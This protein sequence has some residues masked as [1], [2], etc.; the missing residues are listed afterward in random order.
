M[1]F[2]G[3]SPGAD[4]VTA[5]EGFV[6]TAGRCLQKACR[7]AGLD[8][9]TVGR[10]N[11]AKRRPFSDSNDFRKAFYQTIEEPIY[12]PTGKLSKRTAKTTL[13]TAEYDEWQ[14]LLAEELRHHN[15]NLI[16]AAGNEALTA[17]TGVSGI[18]NYR[19]SVLESRGAF[20]RPDGY[21]FKVLA[22]Y[23]PSYIVQG[24]IHEF[25]ILAHDLRKAKR[26]AEFAEVRREPYE[27]IISPTI[28]QISLL[29]AYVRDS[30][31]RWT[32]D[33]ETRAG[34][35]ACFGI[36]CRWPSSTLVGLC[37]PIQTTVGP[38]W[39]PED[40]CAIWEVLHAA[41]TANPNLINQN[42]PYDIYYL[43]KYGIEPSGVYIDTM[44][45]H[46]LLYP[47]FPKGLDFLCSFYLDDCVYYKSEGRNWSAGDRDEDLWKYN[48]KDAVFT[49]RIAEKQEQ[50]ARQR[51]LWEFYRGSM[52]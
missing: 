7:V 50:E 47:E 36:G 17:I 42:L 46:S 30:G 3:E 20:T 31:C 49:L 40:E 39:S 9:A 35:L 10:S 21:P 13:W 52:S 34:T 26:E 23:H 6:G 38:Y 33:V 8:W 37:I 29:L 24:G 28:D 45:L 14:N 15:P 11:L 19:G 44:L 51:G 1:V 5:K 48:I 27:E 4:E 18:T 12:T 43:L 41:A 32:L 22:T 25:F 16:V 2:I